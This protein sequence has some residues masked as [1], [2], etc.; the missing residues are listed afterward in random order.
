MDPGTGK[1]QELSISL[2]E[3]LLQERLVA[4]FGSREAGA[5]AALQHFGHRFTR[6][7]AFAVIDA[8][9][10]EPGK[11]RPST[12]SIILHLPSSHWQ[13]FTLS[14]QEALAKLLADPESDPKLLEAINS[15]PFSATKSWT[16]LALSSSASG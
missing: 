14:Y 8:N 5:I 11:F 9:S 13:V 16:P 3:E 2:Q 12:G 10:F 15:D 1:S 6:V 7:R 4:K